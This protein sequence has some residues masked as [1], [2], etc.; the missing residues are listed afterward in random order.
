MGFLASQHIQGLDGPNW[1]G[2]AKGNLLNLLDQYGRPPVR[3]LDLVLSEGE[4][5][6]GWV[7]IR[8]QTLVADG[9]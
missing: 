7:V 8:Y 3:L 9:V 1:R 6:A 5:D 2:Y 4:V